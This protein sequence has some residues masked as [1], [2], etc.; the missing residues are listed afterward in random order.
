MRIHGVPVL[1]GTAAIPELVERFGVQ[2]VVIAIPS[3]SRTA[4]RRI[5]EPCIASGVEFKI[6]P[7]LREVLDGR[8]R[9]SQLRPVEIEDLLG[10]EVVD[11]EGDRREPAGSRA[12]P[13]W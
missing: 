13:C 5:V 7:S 2:L 1:G 9:L 10:R 3:A 6:V 8:A 4:M 11:L 12:A